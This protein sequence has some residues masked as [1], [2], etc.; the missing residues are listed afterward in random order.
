[1][2][3]PRSCL[4]WLVFQA[5]LYRIPCTL[6]LPVTR[7]W[8]RMVPARWEVPS[9]FL[10]SCLSSFFSPFPLIPYFFAFLLSHFLTLPSCFLASFLPCFLLFYFFTFLL[11]YVLFFLNQLD[12]LKTLKY[13]HCYP[14]IKVRAGR[15]LLLSNKKSRFPISSSDM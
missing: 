2:S 5:L 6:H 7:R 3:I 9:H 1:M 10:L 4:E 11:S 14:P 12:A 8:S 13:P 15:F